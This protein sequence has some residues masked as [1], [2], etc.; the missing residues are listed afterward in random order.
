MIHYIIDYGAFLLGT[1]LYILLKAKK[2]KEI[3]EANPDPNVAFNW[4]KFRDKE[5][6]NL[7]ILLLGGVALVIFTPMLIGGATVE[8]KSTEGNVVA[9]ISLQTLLAPFYF[10]MAMAG[11]SA[12]LNFF[13]TYE[14]TLLNRVGVNPN[15][16]N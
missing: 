6:I 2:L 16:Q 10:L 14:K 11:P 13:G 3:G 4:I 12:L 7:A 1:T 15:T 9:N 5:Y 8:I